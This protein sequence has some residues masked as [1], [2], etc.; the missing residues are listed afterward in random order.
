M[1]TRLDSNNFVCFTKLLIKRLKFH[2]IKKNYKKKVFRYLYFYVIKTSFLLN[3][4]DAYETFR[5]T[6]FIFLNSCSQV[7]EKLIWKK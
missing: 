4:V 1:F 3:S 7:S 2:I 6:I 5:E